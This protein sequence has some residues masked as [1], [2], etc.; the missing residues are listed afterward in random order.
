MEK[1]VSIL[2]GCRKKA[3]WLAVFAAALLIPA[4]AA[5][6]VRTTD[7]TAPNPFGTAG[8][9]MI[10]EDDPFAGREVVEVRV[11]W[12]VVVADGHDAADI[13]ADVH[14][15]IH[16]YSGTAGITLDGTT[17]GWSGSGT[18]N[19]YEATDRY[20]GF[21]GEVGTAWWWQSWGLP[22]DAV[23][24]LPTSRIEIDY[25]VP[26]PSTTTMM[27]MGLLGLTFCGWRLKR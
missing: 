25:L 26:E 5:A 12:D 10:F 27:V 21:F 14:L 2:T 7:F 15:P 3:C 6:D 11:A 8:D 17:L 4:L 19:H 20:N 13:L 16:P 18:F 24:V 23:D 9:G 1:N 22:F